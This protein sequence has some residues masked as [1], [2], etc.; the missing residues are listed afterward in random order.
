MI[1][2]YKKLILIF[3]EKFAQLLTSPSRSENQIWNTN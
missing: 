2:K 3:F 1:W